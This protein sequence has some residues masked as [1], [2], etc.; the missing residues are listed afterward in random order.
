MKSLASEAVKSIG[1]DG[2]AM[3]LAE[4]SAKL[5]AC[6]VRLASIIRASGLQPQVLDDM[7]AS[8]TKQVVSCYVDVVAAASM[9]GV[10]DVSKMVE[11][12]L[13]QAKGVHCSWS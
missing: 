11:K 3:M 5:S 13:E 10:V 4:S 7:V 2:A 1:V 6:S 12:R 9:V 8:T